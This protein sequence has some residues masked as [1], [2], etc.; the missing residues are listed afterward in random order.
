MLSLSSM[1]KLRKYFFTMKCTILHKLNVFICKNY[2]GI[3]PIP[4]NV[5]YSS[6][7]VVFTSDVKPFVQLKSASNLADKTY[8]IEFLTQK[9]QDSFLKLLELSCKMCKNKHF[10]SFEMLNDHMKK[11]HDL[12]Y[13]DLCV[14]NLKVIMCHVQSLL[15]I[16]REFVTLSKDCVKDE[17]RVFSFKLFP[18]DEKPQSIR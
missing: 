12:F 2:N 16:V 10:R 18:V 4:S 6:F 17:L 1:H 3:F 9:I 15:Q 8:G 13:C 5:F 7:Q 11:A 14:E